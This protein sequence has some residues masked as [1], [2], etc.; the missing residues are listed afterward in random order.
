MTDLLAP[1]LDW[2]A[3]TGAPN[4]VLVLALLTHPS[5]WTRA[6]LERVRPLLDR[7]LGGAAGDGSA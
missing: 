1:L 5:T 7:V 2:A 6:V 3:G 4:W